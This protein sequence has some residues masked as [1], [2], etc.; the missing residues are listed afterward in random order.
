M[1]TKPN[2]SNKKNRYGLIDG[3]PT[4]FDIEYILSIDHKCVICAQSINENDINLN[5]IVNIDEFGFCHKECIEDIGIKYFH[6][7]TFDFSSPAF[8]VK[9]KKRYRWKELTAGKIYYDERTKLF[10]QCV[11]I[12]NK[13][14][15]AFTEGHCN[16]ALSK[17][18]N[19]KIFLDYKTIKT[20]L[21]FDI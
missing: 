15:I 20:L 14:R 10:M 19:N 21:R 1:R 9:N 6:I 17:Q 16:Y 4:S 7:K 12:L 13:N 11:D 18:S 8:L 3:V 5:K 2:E